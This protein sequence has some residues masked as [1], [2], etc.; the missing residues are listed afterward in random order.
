[1]PT[2]RRNVL[3]EEVFTYRVHKKGAV[4]ISYQGAPVTVLRGAAAAAAQ[5]RLERLEGRALQLELAKLTGNF[6]RGNGRRALR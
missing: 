6:K 4:F 2:D 5:R 3:A 1:M